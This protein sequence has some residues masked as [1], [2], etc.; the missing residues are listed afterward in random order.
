MLGMNKISRQLIALVIVAFN[1]FTIGVASLVG[2]QSYHDMEDIAVQQVE[3]AAK[4]FSS[5]FEA[6]VRRTHGALTDMES[7]RSVLDQ[8][9]LLNNYG[10]L[11][12]EDSSLLNTSMSQADNSYYFQSQLQL[13]RS[14]IHLLP[15]YELSQVALYQKDPFDQFDHATPL[16]SLLIDHQYIWLYRYQEKSPTSAYSVYKLPIAQIN[17]E[18]DFFNVSTIYQQDADYFY[19]KIGA[20]ITDDQPFDYL[21]NLSRPKSFTSGHVVNLAQD[22]LNVAIWAPISMALTDPES[23]QVEARHAVVMMAIHTPNTASLETIAERIGADIAIADDEHVWVS[24]IDNKKRQ[25]VSNTN[26]EVNEHPY[27]FFEVDLN[28]PSDSN[29]EFNIMALSSTQDLSKRTTSLIV[30]LTLITGLIILVTGLAM[31]WLIRIKLRN[32]L[33]ALLQGVHQIQQGQQ[34][35]QVNIK[36]Q[37]EFNILGSSFNNMSQEIQQK[38]L[39]LRLANEN[40][41]QKVQART[42]EL[43]NAQQ[44][45]IMAEKMASLGQLVAGIAHEINTPLGNSIT[46]L[47]FSHDS[48]KKIKK[49]FDDK[50]LTSN[51][52]GLFLEESDESM[53]L[54]ES[55][56]R[57]ASELVKTFKNVAVNQ[58]V[59][60]LVEFS[61]AD[62]VREVMLTLRPQL[63]KT[64]I[65]V[66]FDIDESLTI[67]SY[68]G[69][70]YHIISNMIMNSLKHAFPSNRGHIYLAIHI[71]EE[72]ILISYKDDGQGMEKE[73]LNRIFDPFYTTK[74]GEGGTG[75]GLYMTYN[76]VCQRLDGKIEAYSALGEGTRFEI[77]LPLNIQGSNEHHKDFSV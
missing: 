53:S 52:F 6:Q 74:R 29:T 17:F 34:D 23:W 59:E 2:Y 15:L 49:L 64:Q 10:P 24:S 9:V 75:L 61:V 11:Y 72:Q 4:L 69:A 28:L 45:L 37:N 39:E 55:N 70:Y 41:E 35:V 21:N 13:A 77:I 30:R 26:I 56:L 18:D 38:S 33:E 44:Q 68:P 32:P 14:L 12:S 58:S 73:V 31:Y 7:N 60:E 50:K 66:N 67:T 36:A 20:F 54:M 16:P 47:S 65:E 22:S 27:V 51:D 19:K 40:L 1:V 76:I 71:K 42:A 62:H 48:Q 57:K 63:K 46:A 25:Q 8:L 3:W 5:E 43:A